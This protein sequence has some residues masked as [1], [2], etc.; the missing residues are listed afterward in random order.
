MMW[1]RWAVVGLVIGL[2][3]PAAA[4]AQAGIHYVYDRLNRLVGVVDQSGNSATYQYDQTGNIV[5]IQRTDAATISGPVGVTLVSPSSGRAGTAVSIFGKGFSATPSENS[6]TFNGAPATVT[7]S[8]PN[9]LT[10]A[11]PP[12]AV[13]GPIS[14]TSPSGSATSSTSFTVQ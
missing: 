8:E 1:W 6:V 14:V 12:D 13:S 4:G 9:V 5:A 3:L 11:V 10:V 2:L 7:A